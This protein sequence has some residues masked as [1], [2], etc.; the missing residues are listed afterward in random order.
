MHSIPQAM[1]WDYWRK[2]YWQHLLSWGVM[3][4]MPIFVYTV[5][6]FRALNREDLRQ[7]GFLGFH[8]ACLLFQALALA[9]PAISAQENIARFYPWPITTGALV[10]WRL[11]PGMTTMALLSCSTAM[12]INLIFGVSWPLVGPALF[13]A[14]AYPMLQGAVWI[15][16]KAPLVQVALASIE[17]AALGSWYQARHGGWFAAPTHTWSEVTLGE[18]LTMFFFAA[19]GW[20]VAYEGVRRDR[21]GE[22][23]RWLRFYDWLESWSFPARTDA[24][25]FRSPAQAQFW[26]EW[27]Q[28]GL[29][30]PAVVVCG[31]SALG[32]VIAIRRLGFGRNEQEDFVLIA[33]LTG[34][35][36]PLIGFL[37]GI[38]TGQT[39]TGRDKTVMGAFLATRP[40][41][42]GAISRPILAV[43]FLSTLLAWGIWAVVVFILCRTHDPRNLMT[44]TA[45]HLLPTYQWY[46][47]LLL[48]ATWSGASMA[49]CAIK[50]GRMRVLIQIAST[51]LALIVTWILLAGPVWKLGPLGAT[52]PLTLLAIAATV[53]TV[54]GF[55]RALERRLIPHPIA[56]LSLAGWI[57]GCVAIELTVRVLVEAP[58]RDQS[59]VV[60]SIIGYGLVA[61]A[62]AP[63]AL[64]PLAIAWN[65]HR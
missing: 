23:L 50:T 21:C 34:L 33:V 20:C 63:L 51:L 58:A 8:F 18:V 49:A 56:W 35:L 40:I 52:I 10:T 43:A 54:V 55:S 47:F 41:A 7:E 25:P 38:V 48:P 2:S 42:D 53:G 39:G 61:L 26:F 30:M 32:L 14:S 46:V 5:I 3:L 28:K 36:L 60:F 22:S 31:L 44:N 9:A 1:T 45:R 29:M 57:V 24:P 37:V 13:L 11:I 17:A 15:G 62:F 16:E 12:I 19:V 59:H 6:S 64:G 65:R 4:F 27:R